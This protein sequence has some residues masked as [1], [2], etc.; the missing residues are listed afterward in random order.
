MLMAC[1]H[2]H[3]CCHCVIARCEIRRRV[4]ITIRQW[5]RNGS[6]S[7][8]VQRHAAAVMLVRAGKRV[9]SPRIAYTITQRPM[10][11]GLR[12][13]NGSR[14]E[15]GLTPDTASLWADIIRLHPAHLH[16]SECIN[17]SQP[18][19]A[20]IVA[21]RTL[22]PPECVFPGTRAS[23]TPTRLPTLRGWQGHA[24]E[25]LGSFSSP[26]C[27]SA[28]SREVSARAPTGQSQGRG[29]WTLHAQSAW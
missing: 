3:A 14:V 11:D 26:G 1:R 12:Q 23:G 29:A 17:K 13:R 19:T 25:A 7:R 2:G 21:R 18:S 9:P 6:C 28:G 15:A 27:A 20:L 24:S 10:L 8:A 4:V 16:L 22:S 5:A